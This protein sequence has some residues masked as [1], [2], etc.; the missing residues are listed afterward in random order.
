MKTLLII[1][2]MSTICSGLTIQDNQVLNITGRMSVGN[3]ICLDNSIAYVS[4]LTGH[5]QILTILA[6]DNSQVL[7]D[8]PVLNFSYQNGLYGAGSVR[9]VCW[10]GQ[11]FYCDIVDS[12]SFGHIHQIPE[13]ISLILLVS[14]I[15]FIK[16]SV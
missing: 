4:N 9:G 13:P 1:S 3:L 16:L 15:G 5:S 10:N 14:G 2:L 7:F 8:V 11:A 12:T 6:K